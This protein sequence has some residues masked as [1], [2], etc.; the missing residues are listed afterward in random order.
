MS[1]SIISRVAAGAALAASALSAPALLAPQSGATAESSIAVTM[2]GSAMSVVNTGTIGCRQTAHA[3][4]KNPDG[5]PVTGGN[6]DFF[7]HLSGLS[8]NL[9]GTSAVTNGNATISWIPNRA[10]QHVISAIFYNDG[11]GEQPVAGSAVVTVL[12]YRGFCI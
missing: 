6:V 2:T 10:G 12:P 9:V 8:G 3:A 11:A 5:S 1:G 4:V 7:S